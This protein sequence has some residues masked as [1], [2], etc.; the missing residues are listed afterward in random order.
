MPDSEQLGRRAGLG[1]GG[2]MR[3]FSGGVNGVTEAIRNGDNAFRQVDG[4]LRGRPPAVPVTPS[5]IEAVQL[6]VFNLIRDG[7]AEVDR[8]GSIR[9]PLAV[10]KFTEALRLLLT[11]PA[12]AMASGNAHD[13][14]GPSQVVAQAL[15]DLR[16]SI[17]LARLAQGKGT[18][19]DLV[20]V[21]KQIEEM[22]GRLRA[23]AEASTM[24]SAAVVATQAPAPERVAPHTDEPAPRPRTKRGKKAPASEAFIAWVEAMADETHDGKI[25]GYVDRLRSGAATEKQVT[26]WLNAKMKSG[27]YGEP[28]KVFDR[29]AKKAEASEM[30]RFAGLVA[31]ELG[32]HEVVDAAAR[33]REGEITEDAFLQA[34]KAHAD[35]DHIQEAMAR[36]Q[37]RMGG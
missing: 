14:A 31:E 7:R 2:L 33:F 20:G 11:A 27:N 16:G 6:Q 1:L 26:A 23:A 18:P 9:A 19:E 22:P 32:V 35:Q 25:R 4:A 17:G 8:T 5:T 34:M 28:Q 36:A 13:L 3:M 37:E 24:A 15:T 30:P 10:M 21:M 29:A 12:S